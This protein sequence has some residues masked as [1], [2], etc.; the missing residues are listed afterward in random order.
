MVRSLEIGR[1]SRK[2]SA[3][4]GRGMIRFCILLLSVSLAL[5]GTAQQG[6]EQKPLR[7]AVVEPIDGSGIPLESMNALRQCLVGI[8]GS[9]GVGNR[10]H[11]ARCAEDQ[12]DRASHR[13][14][15]ATGQSVALPSRWFGDG[16]RSIYRGVIF[17]HMRPGER[18]R[19]KLLSS[20]HEEFANR[21]DTPPLHF[22]AD[23]IPSDVFLL[24][25]EAD[26]WLG[27]DWNADLR[28][29]DDE[30][31]SL[32][33]TRSD[34]H[35]LARFRSAIL[36]I[37]PS[38]RD[39]HTPQDVL[40]IQLWTPTSEAASRPDGLAATLIQLDRVGNVELV[41]IDCGEQS[42]PSANRAIGPAD[43]VVAF[44]AA[45]RHRCD[46]VCVDLAMCHGDPTIAAKRIAR[47][48][49]ASKLPVMV[50]L[51]T[52][53]SPTYRTDPNLRT[54]PD[55][56]ENL[57]QQR[58]DTEQFRK[59]LIAMLDKLRGSAHH[60]VAG[61]RS[62]SPELAADPVKQ[63]PDV[64]ARVTA[65]DLKSV[66]SLDARSQ[67]DTLI[68]RIPVDAV[69]G[70]PRIGVTDLISLSHHQTARFY[71]HLGRLVS[72]SLPRSGGSAR[73]YPLAEAARASAGFV[74][75]NRSEMMR[76]NGNAFKNES[77]QPTLDFVRG[78]NP[79]V[80]IRSGGARHRQSVRL[81]GVTELPPTLQVQGFS[82]L[83][84]L[85]PCDESQ[86]PRA[87]RTSAARLIGRSPQ[88]QTW[89]YRSAPW[90]GGNSGRFL[91]QDQLSENP[92]FDDS[93]IQVWQF[94]NTGT[95][96]SGSSMLG[97]VDAANDWIRWLLVEAVLPD[98]GSAESA[99][100][101]IECLPSTQTMIPREMQFAR[102]SHSRIAPDSGEALWIDQF[103][104][105]VGFG[106]GSLLEQ[107]D[108]IWGGLF[109]PA[110]SGRLVRWLK[111]ERSDHHHVWNDPQ[112]ELLRRPLWWPAYRSDAAATEVRQR[113]VDGQSPGE[114]LRE[115][116]VDD[117]ASLGDDG[118]NLRRP[119]L[120]LDQ[121]E[122]RKNHLD[123]VV[124]AA[125]RVIG[126]CSGR[127]GG[128]PTPIDPVMIEA[129]HAAG[130]GQ[131]PP[132]ADHPP[133]K[134]P[135]S[136]SDEPAALQNYA[137]AVDALYRKFRALGYMELPEVL[138]RHSI[139]DRVAHDRELN[140]TFFQLAAMVD[141]NDPEFVLARVRRQRRD[142][143]PELSQ[144]HLQTYAAKHDDPD[145]YFKKARDLWD[146]MEVGL[147]QRLGHA[148][149]FLR[150]IGGALP[151]Q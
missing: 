118:L 79:V 142:G 141:M 73:N 46:L 94:W 13:V 113:R 21:S 123:R 92:N 28:I 102:T 151:P 70:T 84:K 72:N 86:V 87:V 82:Y 62:R 38:P 81:I 110:P 26:A 134:R 111:I 74:T 147:P 115:M 5:T 1:F 34:R 19:T 14:T 121:P 120:A 44:D 144:V 89:W 39:E 65:G 58:P 93:Q 117:P 52:I 83:R 7:I 11:L 95:P 51:P 125:D 4:D 136:L 59:S 76:I 149:W 119:L 43:L 122:I 15:G 71:D 40:E 114:V 104:S 96:D 9:A 63:L 112:R 124:A 30:I 54:V 137:W 29:S 132:S 24:R 138:Q 33:G 12:I 85:A 107:C 35:T 116:A 27:C 60:Q 6:D 128:L 133:D 56:A 68:S 101:L 57:F 98:G 148:R 131:G 129:M 67:S 32:S 22:S 3:C 17:G 130:G 135:F 61:V 31:L 23:Q 36:L 18:S 41:W 127:L 126:H 49:E 75:V 78:K 103:E 16:Q 37:Q 47:L 55:I 50:N 90:S 88:V 25:T 99:P 48:A 108:A 145:W 100:H 143:H 139:A 97:T 53:V 66:T 150:E 77:Q 45:K 69:A 109:E 80:T 8:D 140:A 105:S 42:Y 20:W 146:D 2:R 64:F 10:I 91:F 106:Y